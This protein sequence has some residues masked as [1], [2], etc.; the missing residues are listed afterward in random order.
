MKGA[1]KNHFFAPVLSHVYKTAKR[2]PIRNT[3]APLFDG[4]IDEYMKAAVQSDAAKV[5]AALLNKVKVCPTCGKPNGFSLSQCNKCQ[6]DLEL[7]SITSTTNLFSAFILG[8][9]RTPRFPLT[10]SIRAESDDILVFDDPLAISPLHFCAIPTKLFIPDWRYLLL[11]PSAG[12]AICER[13]AGGSHTAAEK[14]F[15]DDKTWTDSLVNR[16]GLSTFDLRRDVIMGFNFPPSQ[17]QLHIQYMLPLFMPH[18]YM[19]FL[20]GVHFTYERFFPLKYVQHCLATLNDRADTVLTEKDIDVPIG[21]LV[22]R[23]DSLCGISYE[24][25]HRDFLARVDALH[26]KLAKWSKENFRGSCS[27]AK[28]KGRLLCKLFTNTDA[29]TSSPV[30]RA[31]H[32][33][34]EQ[35]KKELQTYA[36]TRCEAS[37]SSV[38]SVG[39]YSHAKTIADLSFEFVTLQTE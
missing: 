14:Q 24:A 29:E 35:E 28:E 22:Q 36:K 18:Q 10:V 8:I 32:E 9:G 1:S 31:D 4:T 37:L 19:M 30:T 15:L 25:E 17:N 21:Q 20:N 39:F 5:N 38:A 7:V 12:L 23:L 13:L 2:A 34:F 3:S 26:G 6:T 11:K 27:P 16:D 33:V